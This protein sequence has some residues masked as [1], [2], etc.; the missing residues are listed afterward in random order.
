M[1]II[2]H[3][4]EQTYIEKLSQSKKLSQSYLFFGPES[5]GKQLL[6]FQFACNLVGEPNFQVSEQQAAPLDIARIEPEKV[7]RR[8]VVR[9]KT[10]GV[11]LVRDQ[12]KFL[13]MSPS[14]GSYR[15]LIVIDAH[16]LTPAA[17]NVLLKFSEEPDP[18]AI[19]IFVT[20][21]RG[22]ILETLCSRL[23]E[24][25]FRFVPEEIIL[26]EGK[27]FN[28][29]PGD[30][31][32]NFFFQLGRPG[33][34]FQAKENPKSFLKHKEQLT[35]LYRIST[36]SLRERLKLAEELAVD[37]PGSIQLFEWF[38]PGLYQRM[39]GVPV[40]TQV[41]HLKVLARIQES[42]FQLKKTDVQPRLTL[43]QLFLTLN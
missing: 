29:I 4:Q 7:V 39:K 27:P 32:P 13:K 20:H 14:S 3:H 41:K 21:D 33:I 31:I 18:T 28:L 12:L 30:D 37:V 6:A 8:G 16:L 40:D 5:I 23:E 36:L 15:V 38:L 24:V 11:T 9:K 35:S 25:R 10:M 1:T 2:G 19:I 34:L 17:Q 26:E 22:A 42:L 43:E